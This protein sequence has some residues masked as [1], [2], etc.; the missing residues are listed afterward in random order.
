M[1]LLEGSWQEAVG[2]DLGSLYWK[3]TTLPYVPAWVAWVRK[4][5]CLRRVEEFPVLHRLRGL[6]DKT[7]P[8]SG[9]LPVPALPLSPKH[10]APYRWAGIPSGA[11]GTTEFKLARLPASGRLLFQASL[12]SPYCLFPR[13]GLQQ[14]HS[15]L[16][17]LAV[18]V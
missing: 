10:G 13:L 3:G 2:V 6:E 1:Q 11:A 9:G 18:G 5:G 15:A 8:P 16:W 17:I 7:F 12:S 14:S 4:A